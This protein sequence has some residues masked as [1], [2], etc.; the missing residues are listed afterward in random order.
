MAT[1]VSPGVSVSVVDESAYASAGL[2][3]TPLILIATGA[4]KLQPGSSTAVAPGTTAAHAN[5][6]YLI[7][8]QR[9]LVQTFGTPKFYTT[10]GTPNY[11][12]QL[13][14]LGL[15]TAYQ[16]LGIANTA[17]VLRADI[18][19]TQMV[20]TSVEPVGSPS[21]GQYWMDTTNTTWGVFTS[22]GNVNSALSWQASNPVVLT[23]STNLEIVVQGK[24]AAISGSA[25]IIA[26]SGNLVINNTSIALTAG[27]SISDV[28]SAVNN[29]AVHMKGISAVVYGRTGK[30]DVTVTAVDDMYH[31]RLVSNSID[32]TIDLINSNSYILTYLGFITNSLPNPE[33]TNTI[34]PKQSYGIVGEYVVDA[35]STNLTTGLME[36]SIWQKIEQ[37]TL[38]GNTTAWW[39]KV[40]SQDVEFPGWGWQQAVPSVIVGTVANPTLVIGTQCTISIGNSIPVTITLSGTTVTSFAA[41]INAVLDAN[42]FN[43]YADIYQSG[44]NQYL[45][46]TNYDASNTQFD[47]ITTQA[48]IT[49]P[50]QT[51]GIPT[52]QTYYGSVT[53]TVSSPTYVA[54]NLYVQS[55]TVV[56]PGAGYAVNDP[57]N[58][59]GGV[60]SVAAVAT[61]TTIQATSA[62]IAATGSGYAQNDTLTFSGAGYLSPVICTVTSVGGGGAITGISV[63]QGGQFNTA[64]PSNPVTPSGTS[65]GGNGVTVTLGWGVGAVTVTIAGNYTQA[66]TNPVA[67][68]GGSGTNATLN[69]TMNYLISNTFSIDPGTGN[70]ITVHV[71]AAP[72]NNLTGVVSA[73]N[74]AFPTGPIAASVATGNYLK[75]TNTNGTQF[76]IQDISGTPLSSSGIQ[77]GYTY[78]RQM[79]YQGYYPSLTVPSSLAQLAATNVWINTTPQDRGTSISIKK[80]NG[81][82]WIPQNTNPATGTIPMYSSDAV[83]NAGFGSTK[84]IGT[85]YAR[86]NN[87]GNNP[88]IANT[89]V[90]EWDGSAWITFDYTP[91]ATAPSGSPANGTLW[92]N[93]YLQVDIMVGNGQIWQGYSNAYPATDPNGAIIDGSMPTT[94]SDGYSPLVTNDIWIDSSATPYP[95]I[96]RYDG[97]SGTFALVDNTNHSSPSG[98]IFSDARWNNN[99]QTTGSQAPSAM[100]VSNYVD[101][102]APNAEL[103]PAG[104]LLFNTRFSTYNVKQYYKNYF[105]TL[106]APYD[107]DCWVTASGNRPDGTPYMGTDAQR[108]MVSTALN[109]S[110][111]S[112]QAIRGDAIYYNLLATPGYIECLPAMQSLN[113]SRNYTGFIV[114]DPPGTLPA[115]TTSLQTWAS[116]ANNAALDG[117]D[118]LVS[119]SDSYSGVYYPWALAT[120]LDGTNVFVPPSEMALRTIAYNDQVAYPWFAPAGF[121]RGLVT[122]VNSVGYLKS[123]GTYQ[124]VSLNQGQRDVL[125]INRINPISFIPNRGLVIFGQKTLDPI[126]TALDRINVARLINYLAYNL[127]TIAQPF[128]FEPNDQQTRQAVTNVFNSFMANLVGLRA[129]Y[130][131]AVVCDTTNNT[132]VTIDRNELWIDVAIKPEKAIE[133]IYIPIRI[134]NT[135]DPMPGGAQ[136]QGQQT[137]I[138]G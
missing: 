51:A 66:P 115:D 78:G 60:H 35:Y 65:G 99:G 58:I 6:L 14:E 104:M 109:A 48:N 22:N 20:P 80:Y 16:Y 79:I 12:N 32:T 3:T 102:D 81:T 126:A 36:N 44:N 46:I 11:G 116:N 125:Y 132:P 107:P 105:P 40:G 7:S 133:F 136:Q 84:V 29:S 57:L 135:G 93:T 118:G 72:N 108:I 88:P 86:Y 90:Y 43:V 110:L 92:Y 61:V 137:A 101:S 106:S 47:D 62:S 25:N 42:N 124:P 76:T 113:Q 69:V 64:T 77:V 24:T 59:V 74:A 96:Y 83:A 31:M 38:D 91:S 26:T 34:A 94:Q 9:D 27:M 129:L 18:N 17:Y 73:I 128:L 82:A 19:L 112:N 127:N 53:G 67:V 4:N 97:V 5:Q 15:F 117:P 75:I 122:G 121:N 13:N 89:V 130:D 30:P 52:T 123:D 119:S 114:A 138:A 131:Y 54:A 49:H 2:G 55:A 50:W 120:N 33:P 103:Y 37:T 41:D 71:P 63:T 56:A 68:T 21:V 45:R 87:D 98:I 28:A 70:P 95:Q 111:E 39:F 134:L 10:A 1:L 100:V 8:S 23:D 85:I